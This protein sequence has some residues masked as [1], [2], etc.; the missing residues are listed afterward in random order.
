MNYTAPIL[1]SLIPSLII[2]AIVI[3][4]M[5]KKNK[6]IRIATDAAVYT[7]HESINLVVN[8]DE[9]VNSITNRTYI[10]PASSGSSGGGG[11]SS[12]IGHSG[13]G[14]SSGG[15]RHG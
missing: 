3:S 13:G 10:P 12:S 15:G 5:V 4:G 9:L 14:H 8:R 11:H 1:P 6:M 7:N 2:T